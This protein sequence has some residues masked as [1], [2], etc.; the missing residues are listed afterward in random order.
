MGGMLVNAFIN[1]VKKR[2]GKGVFLTT[3]AQNNDKVN[4]FYQNIGFTLESSYA[5]P[6]GRKM[7]RYVMQF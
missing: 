6:E 1:E 7:N 5:T 2:G 3:D 4:R